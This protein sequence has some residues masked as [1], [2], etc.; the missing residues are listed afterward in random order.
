V[1]PAEAEILR[2]RGCELGNVRLGLRFVLLIAGLVVL[3]GLTGRRLASNVRFGLEF[4]GGYEIYYVVSPGEGKSRL[5]SE[6]L[7]ATTDILGRRADSIGMAEPEIHIEGENHI[8]VKLAGLTSADE[9][10]SLLGSSEG[11][12]VVLTEKYT[13]TVGSVLGATALKET[14]TAGAIGIGCVVLLLL[15][16]YRGMGA[17]AALCTFV[18]LWLLLLAFNAS[19][20][21]LSLSAVVAFVLGIGMA[22]DAGIICFERVREEL[23]QG[24][25]P[26]AA[27][28]LGFKESWSTIRDANLVTALAMAA[29]FV[30]GIGPIQ[31]F[32]L[33][34]LASIAISVATNFF[35]LR[36]LCLWLAESGVL[37]PKAL[38]GG[39]VDQGRK[40]RAIDFVR[41]GRSA[42]V[43][44]ALLIVAGGLYYRAHGLN[45]DIDFTAGT[46]LDIDLDRS[47]DQDTATRIM[48]D[49]GTV[50]ATVAIGGK[51]D[52]HIA[53]RFDEILKPEALKRI[54]GAFKS[55]YTHVEYEENTADPGVAHEFV[56]R[57]IYAVLA[58]FAGIALYIGLRFSWA[59]ALATVAPILH[60]L[61]AVTALFSLFKLEIDVTYIAALL[62]ITGY[63]L[64]DKIVIFGRI[65]ENSRAFTETADASLRDLVN[66]SIR[67]TLRRSIFTVLTM[68]MASACLYLFACEPLQM[69]ALAILIGLISGAYSSIFL[70]S[71]LWL[72]VRGR[73]GRTKPL[74]VTVAAVGALG[75]MGWVI[76][77]GMLPAPEQAALVGQSKTVTPLG[78]LGPFSKITSDVQAL[79]QGG[80]L[81]AA[82]SRIA[83]LESA[84][85]EAEE[86]LRPMS[87]GDWTAVDKAIDR[88]LAQ[89]RSG[90]PDAAEC[91]RALTTLLAKMSSLASSGATQGGAS[92]GPLG[93]LAPFREIAQG[94]LTLAESGDLSGA[95]A[96]IT[97][98]E[99]TWDE[100]GVKLRSGDSADWGG[101]DKA[102]D[103]AKTHLR[104]SSPVGTDCVTAL[105]ALIAKIDSVQHER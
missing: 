102:I 105:K 60:D 103:R 79:V 71:L 19:H 17:V 20:A 62:T 3:M 51:N 8:R 74:L 31:G 4:R 30:A 42:L 78:D 64:N 16:L 91:E 28:R 37:S 85:D 24:H 59:I 48:S 88:A 99:T 101:I 26:P 44:S 35:L 45:L 73:L 47:I 72:A 34:M 11:L 69:F 21:T 25:A 29:L 36:V 96:R 98:L 94:A 83:D 68:V 86:K 22:A 84:W 67:Q 76:L 65:R 93:D 90:V 27:V 81:V 54:I 15:L 33:T 55:Q 5:T 18:Y 53:T 1:S 82:K 46:A 89:L 75:A 63:S 70:S 95:K 39:A 77:P 80:D 57:A 52:E 6:D 14:L 66:V 23:A 104:S 2:A 10:R 7:L 43:V 58:A 87:P 38:V 100:A 40:R 9:S 97:D 13:Q 50:P 41:L 92:S 12:P 32:S 49:A 56:V 61:L